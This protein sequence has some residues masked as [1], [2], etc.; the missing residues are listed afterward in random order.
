MPVDYSSLTPRARP[1][2]K[3]LVT[4]ATAAAV[5]TIGTGLFL[6][7]G[8]GADAIDS[9]PAGA[10]V[11]IPT[12]AAQKPSRPT[13]TLA[14]VLPQ[15][16]PAA[17]TI[18][19]ALP[20]TKPFDPW[21]R[22]TIRQGQTLSTVFADAG[23]PPDAWIPVVNAGGDARALRRLRV[24]AALEIKILGG[25][26]VALRYPLDGTRTLQL[27]RSG[28][29]YTVDTATANLTLKPRL[30]SGVIS[31]SLFEAGAQAGLS[32][33]QIMAFAKIFAAQVDFGR[34][35]QPGDRFRVVYDG[36]YREN[37]R[38]G[39]SK[40][41]AAEIQTDGNVYRAVRYTN[42][43]GDDEYY[44]PAGYSL[45]R[46]F[47]RT[48]VDFTRISS[49]FSQA[50]LNPV[51]HIVRPHHGTDL[52]APM[53]AP[54]HATANGRISFIGPNGGY[55]NC[56]KIESGTKYET[57]YGH[58]SRFRSGLRRGAQVTQGEVIGY[59]GMTGIATGPHVHYEIHVNG[60]PENPMTIKLPNGTPLAPGERRRFETQT[61]TLVAALD[62]G[63]TVRYA[64]NGPT[65]G[66]R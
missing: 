4:L 57:I 65:I 60:I 9:A 17:V 61:A 41:L 66:T 18:P 45:H 24:G 19:H 28:G 3:T 46:M 15:A 63:S 42:K 26:L 48:P 52:A 59:V 34:D 40:I 7:R 47:L 30:A 64:A 36:I 23:L 39:T 55:G 54:I 5:A 38:V 62:H 8:A 11:G 25:Q 22:F 2:R 33:R 56:I 29:D 21:K 35:I 27:Q 14:H 50:R 10:V 44:T 31:S 43:A 13:L 51:L 6:T 49:N 12:L 58:M 53:G 37:K 32:D 20:G 1:R 16:I